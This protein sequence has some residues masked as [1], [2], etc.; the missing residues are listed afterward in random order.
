VT[1]HGGPV[2]AR[3]HEIARIASGSEQDASDRGGRG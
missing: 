2:S 3:Q 1:C